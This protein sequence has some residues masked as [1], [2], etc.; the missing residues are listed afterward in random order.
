MADK[1][2]SKAYGKNILISS[3]N[4]RMNMPT[5]FESEKWYHVR[6]RTE[7]EDNKGMKPMWKHSSIFG[8]TFR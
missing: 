5:G 1:L 6:A 7:A 8:K 3:A 4:E 2:F